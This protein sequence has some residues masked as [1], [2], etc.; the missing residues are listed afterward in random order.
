MVHMLFA[1]ASKSLSCSCWNDEGPVGRLHAAPSWWP[2]LLHSVICQSTSA[3]GQHTSSSKSRWDDIRVASIPQAE[4]MVRYA[5][6][7]VVDTAAAAA[8]AGVVPDRDT[9]AVA[10]AAAQELVLVAAA[11]M[12]LADRWP[13]SEAAVGGQ[14]G[15]AAAAAVVTLASGGRQPAE[16]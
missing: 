9:A 11:D 8:A 15:P 3:I 14:L 12:F 7:A 16:K 2:A 13:E 5:A 4:T 6:T 1:A 10:A